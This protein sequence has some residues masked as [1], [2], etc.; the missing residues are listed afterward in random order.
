[1]HLVFGGGWSTGSAERCEAGR[2]REREREGGGVVSDWV[3]GRAQKPQ[4]ASS[5]GKHLAK[6]G[7]QAG[8]MLRGAGAGEHRSAAARS[9]T[10]THSP[11]LGSGESLPARRP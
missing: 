4:P 6:A 3:W 7:R 9:H 5:S 10:L 2:E 11:V 1:M 8:D